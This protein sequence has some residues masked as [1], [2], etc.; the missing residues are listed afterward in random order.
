MGSPNPNSLSPIQM[1][2]S[3]PKMHAQIA[4]FTQNLLSSLHQ[5]NISVA[6]LNMDHVCYRYTSLDSY[7]LAKDSLAE[8]ATL[9]TESIIGGRPIAVFKL[10]PGNEVLFETEGVH[11]ELTVIELA[12]PKLASK[13]TY[14]DGDI[15]HAE[16]VLAEPALLDFVLMHPLK[17]K[18]PGSSLEMQS[19][20]WDMRGL[21]KKVNPDVRIAFS[22]YSAKF[23]LDTLES[24]CVK[25]E[26]E[27]LAQSGLVEKLATLEGV[28]D[29]T[30]QE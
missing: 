4:A 10:N 2:E 11:R 30:F 21:A 3:L 22:T 25:E 29:M 13:Y 14:S 1:F 8:H 19:C 12:S 5:Q 18:H 20:E 15:E 9:I 16:F 28:R 23:H 6:A 17:L 7:T 24:F 27:R 26:K